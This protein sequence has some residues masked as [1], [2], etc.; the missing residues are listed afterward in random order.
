MKFIF[1]AFL[2]LSFVFTSYAQTAT[3]PDKLVTEFDVNGLKVIFKRRPSSP[4]VSAGLF[5]RGGVKN[6]TAQNAGIETLTLSTA[7]E[8]SAKYPREALRKELARTG[9]AISAGAGYDFGVVSLTSTRQNFDK[10]WEIFTDVVTN[11]ALAQEDFQLVRERLLTGLRNQSISPDS[12]LGVLEDKVIYANHPYATEPNGTIESVSNLK[13]EDIRAYHKNLLQTSRLLLVIVG[14]LDPQTV[15]KQ[16]TASFGKLPRG[17][18]K[19]NPTPKIAFT[20]PTLDVTARTIP[21]NYVKGVFAAP[22]LN[23]PDYYAMRV[24]MTILQSRVYQEVRTK[25]NLSY[26]PNAEMDDKAANTANIYVTAN[27]ANQS[28][29]LMLKEIE[30]MKNSEIDEDGF[31]GVPGFFLTTYYINQETNAA[32]VAELARYELIGGGWRNSLAFLDKIRQVTAKD[33]RDVSQKYMKNIR[34]VVVGS[35]AAVNK[36]IFLQN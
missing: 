16:V 11:P 27:D 28:V 32:Q 17:E 18:Y 1:S 26:A 10:T 21:T 4:T 22:S 19:E 34:F 30:S 15:Q 3:S 12:A 13:L 9:S 8:A 31:T 25:R 7:T 35:P 6:Q 2:L 23:D 20:Q 33:V 29:R 24:A 36:E 5:T 14:D